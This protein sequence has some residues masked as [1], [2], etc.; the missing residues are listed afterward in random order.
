LAQAYALYG[1]RRCLE[2]LGRL[3]G[4]WLEA[5]PYAKGA[6]WSSPVEPGIRLI[7]WS[8]VWGLIG[9]D[10]S[11]LF[12]GAQ[13]QLLLHRWLGSIYQHMRF[14]RDNYSKYSSADNHLI[15]EAAGVYV[16]AQVWDRWAQSRQMRCEAKT[17]LERETSLQFSPD[18]V[19]LEQA[20]CYHKFSL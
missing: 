9:A 17:L 6:N 14:V 8:L 1:D 4:S 5:C 12:E 15:G 20:S 11:P 16:A 19:N 10:R 3:L 13:G 18:G 7:N 2:H